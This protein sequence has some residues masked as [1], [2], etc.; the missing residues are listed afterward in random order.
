M[1][2]LN[3]NDPLAVFP[4]PEQAASPEGIVA[5]G[6]D[7]NVGRLV[8]AY[9][10]GIFPWYN[11]Y[12]PILWW[13]PDPRLVLYPG[14]LHVGRS[15]R[16]R[17]KR[18]AV[19]ITFDTDFAGV[20]R[21]CAEPRGD[22]PEGAGT[23]LDPQ[24]IQA[25]RRLHAHGLAHSVEAW[26]EAGNLVGGLYGVALGRVF[27]GESMFTRVTDASKG[28]FV[29]G[30]RTLADHGYRLIDCQVYS[31]HLARFGAVEIPRS[32]FLLELDRALAEPEPAEPWPYAK[33]PERP[34]AD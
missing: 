23:W 6:G 13:S 5:I 19:G 30:V 22:G 11:E 32:R 1:Y 7:L 24:M 2:L 17:L 3:A 20:I 29:H 12:E 28:A 33:R 18:T 8:Q 25:Y 10:Q 34:T 26:D 21:G 4:D 9:R 27:F 14:Q 16:K 15:L 31:D